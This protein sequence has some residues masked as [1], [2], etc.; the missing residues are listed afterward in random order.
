MVDAGPDHLAGVMVRTSEAD[1]VTGAH[2]GVAEGPGEETLALADLPNEQ[3]VFIA[4]GE[5]QRAGGV[6]RA[7]FEADLIGPVEVLEPVDLLEPGSMAVG[8]GRSSSRRWL[9]R[10]TS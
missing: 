7:P 5:L 3:D 2:G 9:R 6:E 4:G 10:L 1:R 8:R